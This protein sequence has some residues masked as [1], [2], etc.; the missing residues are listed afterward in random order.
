MAVSD[1]PHPNPARYRLMQSIGAALML[2][3]VLS[4][5][6]Q[7]GLAFVTGGLLFLLTA[8][9][10]LLMLLPL[11]MMTSATPPLT[12]NE[13]GLTLKPLLWPDRV[14]AWDEI[15]AVKPYPL[16][17]PQDSEMIRRALVGRKKYQVAE[18]IMLVIPGLPLQY[19]A[20]GFFAGEGFTPVVAIT[21][22]THTGYDRLVKQVRLHTGDAQ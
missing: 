18:G 5:P 9:L 20:A 12:I 8:P 22:R 11:A 7:I 15:R 2:V 19:R 17:P 1:H 21:N 16:L 3:I 13:S 6:L 4:V 10:T 14:I